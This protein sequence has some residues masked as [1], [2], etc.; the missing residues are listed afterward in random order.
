MLYYWESQFIRTVWWSFN[1]YGLS[2][3]NY[4]HHGFRRPK[5]DRLIGLSHHNSSRSLLVTYVNWNF[6]MYPL[7]C[8]FSVWSL[9]WTRLRFETSKFLLIQPSPWIVLGL[10]PWID[11]NWPN[12]LELARIGLNWPELDRTSSSHTELVWPCD[13]NLMQIMTRHDQETNLTWRR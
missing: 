8:K 3:L 9:I 5:L 13:S 1:S 12:R 4:G 2:N 11:Q 10:S 6:F 7:A